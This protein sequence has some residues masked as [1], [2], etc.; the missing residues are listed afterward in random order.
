M[1]SCECRQIEFG[2]R[3]LRLSNLD[4][5][6]AIISHYMTFGIKREFSCKFCHTSVRIHQSK[7]WGKNV[8]FVGKVETTHHPLHSSHSH[9]L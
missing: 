2:E 5:K 8:S 9:G 6:M 1:Q 7:L 3:L 4:E